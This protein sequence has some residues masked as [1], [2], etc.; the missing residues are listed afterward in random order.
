MAVAVARAAAD[1]LASVGDSDGVLG[2]GISEHPAFVNKIILALRPPPL[3]MIAPR[4][5]VG[6]KLHQTEVRPSVTIYVNKCY[7]HIILPVVNNR[8]P[9]G[10]LLFT[11]YLY[12]AF[13]CF[14]NTS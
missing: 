1:Y 12:F 2:V 7:F 6:G 11:A 10:G 8:P 14:V 5:V 3:H 13:C 9:N 4:L